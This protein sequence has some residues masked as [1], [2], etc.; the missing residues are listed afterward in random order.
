MEIKCKLDKIVLTTKNRNHV[1]FDYEKLPVYKKKSHFFAKPDKGEKR[2]KTIIRYEHPH[3]YGSLSI[4]LHPMNY[5]QSPYY[6]IFYADYDHDIP[7]HDVMQVV[8]FFKQTLGYDLQVSRVDLAVDIIS[9]KQNLF[10]KVVR[11]IKPGMKGQP[12]KPKKDNGMGNKYKP[13]YEKTLYFGNRNTGV[14]LITY[15]KAYEQKQRGR[16]F[17]EDVVRIELRFYMAKLA[18]PIETVEELGD[19]DWAG[20]YGKYFSIHKLSQKYKKVLRRKGIGT[21]RPI[22]KLRDIM[23]KQGK[24]RGNFYRDCLQE[25]VKAD[26]FREALAGYSWR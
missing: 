5:R 4:C 3:G 19:Y 22:W 8:N 6:I 16:I 26:K 10:K 17:N 18:N 11:N 15:D 1:S 23:E 7:Y 2:Y 12:N 13:D 9:K 20:V 24:A 14:C 21:K 25:H